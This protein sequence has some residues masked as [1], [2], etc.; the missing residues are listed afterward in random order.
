[1][2][3]ASPTSF[4]NWMRG[5]ETTKI[6]DL[7]RLLLIGRFDEVADYIHRLKKSE[8]MTAILMDILCTAS[9]R[10]PEILAKIENF[11]QKLRELA[12]PKRLVE[13]G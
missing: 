9:V 2:W 7:E 8:A 3:K 13:I 6:D 10:K 12:R 11:V 1:M 5:T 4:I